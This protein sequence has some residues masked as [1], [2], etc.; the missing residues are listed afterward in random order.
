MAGTS[1]VPSHHSQGARTGD[2]DG[3]CRTPRNYSR[4]LPGALAWWNTQLYEERA[5]TLFDIVTD[6]LCD[7]ATAPCGSSTSQ[8]R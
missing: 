8:S 3:T 2:R 6:S 1:K 5:Y 7:L 4:G